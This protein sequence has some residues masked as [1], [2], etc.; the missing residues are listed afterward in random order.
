MFIKKAQRQ[1][2]KLRIGVFGAS[3]SG[4]TTSALYLA[5]GLVKDWSKICV[6]DTE[7]QSADL[8]ANHT[9][10]LSGEKCETLGDYNTLTLEAPYTPERYVQ[11]IKLCVDAGIEVVVIDSISHEWEGKGGCLEIKEQLDLGGGNSYTNWGKVTPRHNAFIQA[12]LTAPIH[13]VATSRVKTDV[14]L[15]TNEKGK[16]VPQKVGLKC[17]TRDGFD[18]EM[19][20]CFDV[21]AGSH[22]AKVSKDR[23]GI[24][25]GRPE[26]VISSNDGDLLAQWADSGSEVIERP[27]SKDEFLNEVVKYSRETKTSYQDSVKLFLIEGEADLGQVPESERRSRLKEVRT[28]QGV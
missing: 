16:A 12:M 27:L 6:I 24:F 26:W 11:A 9:P 25:E 17:V 1:K 8:Y 14:A 10:V 22:L 3:G 20:T 13:I 15:T 28:A 21:E 19:T 18:Y 2:A 4:K 7:N 23:T 5:Y